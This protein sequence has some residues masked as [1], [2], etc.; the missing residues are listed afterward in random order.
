MLTPEVMGIFC[1]V[2]LWTTALLVAASALKLRGRLVTRA[3]S[4]G[5]ETDAEI[6]ECDGAFATLA[7]EQIGRALDPPERP[8]IAFHD[9]SYRSTLAGGVLLVN[10][11]RVEVPAA[12]RA[13]VW[14][15]PAR[16]TAAAQ[17]PSTAAF[18]EAYA[19]AKKAKGWIRTVEMSLSKG[20]KIVYYAGET[21]LVSTVRVQRWLAGRARMLLVFAMSS[22]S[23]CGAVT[24][25]ALSKPHFGTLS[26]VGAVLGIAFFLGITPLGV[27]LREQARFPHE[28]RLQG[29]WTRGE[30]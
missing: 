24:V 18:D 22:V 20:D 3:T 1:L 29:V 16:R 12:P 13:E 26:L 28:A 14:L 27:R 15:D 21:P 9:R 17:C 10:G 25:L 8:A 5:R 19:K 7:V 4:L 23:L 11:E 2:V 6:T 30:S